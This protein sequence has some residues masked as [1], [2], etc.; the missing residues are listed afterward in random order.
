MCSSSNSANIDLINTR[1]ENVGALEA[2]IGLLSEA[3][4]RTKT[5]SDSPS[6]ADVGRHSLPVLRRRNQLM[7]ASI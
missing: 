1:L 6:H 5:L 4:A 7:K 3:P 2:P